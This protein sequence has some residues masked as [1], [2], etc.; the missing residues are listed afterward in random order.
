MH[1]DAACQSVSNS[2]ELLVYT[3]YKHTDTQHRA[4]VVRQ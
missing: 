2:H 3:V 1:V 4:L